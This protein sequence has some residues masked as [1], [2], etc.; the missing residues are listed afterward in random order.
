[1]TELCVIKLCVIK[2]CVS[3]L[4]VMEFCESS[5]NGRKATDGR[6]DG[7]VQQKTNT[8]KISFGKTKSPKCT[9]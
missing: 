3:E 1:M 9:V 7:S 8:H 6:P 2:L 5:C 4:W